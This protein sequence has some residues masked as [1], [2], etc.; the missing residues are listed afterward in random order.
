MVSFVPASPAQAVVGENKRRPKRSRQGR[1]MAA[2]LLITEVTDCVRSVVAQRGAAS[3]DE[4]LFALFSG[5]QHLEN[6]FFGWQLARGP[7]GKSRHGI[8][9]ID[10]WV[11]CIDCKKWPNKNLAPC[12]PAFYHLVVECPSTGCG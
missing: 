10:K 1:V 7:P 2:D 12:V 5:E 3:N 8:A 9:S 4:T 11:I 6:R